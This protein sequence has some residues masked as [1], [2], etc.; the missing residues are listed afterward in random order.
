MTL[1]RLILFHYDFQ[2]TIEV[3]NSVKQV[4]EE[5]LVVQDQVGSLTVGS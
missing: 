2:K 4:R 3:D 1:L 5:L